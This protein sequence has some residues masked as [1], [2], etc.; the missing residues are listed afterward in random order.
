[1]DQNTK[2]KE[3]KEV[4]EVKAAKGFTR[5][6]IAKVTGISAMHVGNAPTE[7]ELKSNPKAKTVK[8]PCEI[9][10]RNARYHFETAKGGKKVCSGCLKLVNPTY[11]TQKMIDKMYNVAYYTGSNGPKVPIA[12][13]NNQL[14]ELF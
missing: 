13:R 5:Y 12:V 9:C 6:E 8:A 11:F 4:K 1:M 3:V 10:Q 7:E 14:K 2:G